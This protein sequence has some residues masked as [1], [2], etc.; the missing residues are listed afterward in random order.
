M[1]PNDAITATLV[2]K[3][4][5]AVQWVVGMPG[6]LVVGTS[7]GAW[8]V[9][10]GG[11]N[12]PITPATITATPQAYNGS[13]ALQPLTINFDIIYVQENVVRD[14]SYNYYVNIYTGTDI[15]ILSNHLFYGYTIPEWTY[16]EKPFKSIWAVR[17]DGAMLSCAYVKEQE[18]VGWARHDT[19]GLYKSIISIR[20]G[21][22][23]IVYTI[24][25]R[26]IQGNSVQ[27][28]ERFPS[29]L[30][31]YGV[32]DAWALDCA[33]QSKLVYPSATLTADAATGDGVTFA[34]NVGVFAV[35]DIGST[36]RVG[37]GI[38]TITKFVNSQTLIGNITQDIT[39]ILPNSL[40]PVLLPAPAGTWSLTPNFT[41]FSGLA[42]LEGQTVSI[43]GDGNVFTNKVV[44][45]G[46]VMLN[47]PASKVLV[48]LP[49]LPQAK[50]L[51]LDT[52]E[53]TIQAKRKK[54]TAV[55]MRVDQ[56]RGL[57]TGPTFASDDLV[58]YKDRDNEPMGQA[59]P[60][61]TGDERVNVSPLWGE[62]G[63]ICVQ[64]DYPLPATLLGLIFEYQVGDK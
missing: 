46:I 59:V 9:S 15:S 58:E 48:G 3:Q 43:L 40:N 7:G 49:Y 6:G 54:I 44:T 18:M 1:Q 47:E 28:I 23:D 62:T 11:A 24:V 63:Q 60:L 31:P 14:L 8:Q 25:Q 35:T 21:A 51:Y 17:S 30:M 34:A 52:G 27:Y 2:S 4:I 55:S 39:A 19:L 56:T 5:N 16:A 61:Y 41:T 45:N 37:G 57:A 20:E 38:A 33:L 26:I 29:R 50:T 10:G 13:S 42:H 32:E 64:Q 53:P 22:E 12:A 36:L